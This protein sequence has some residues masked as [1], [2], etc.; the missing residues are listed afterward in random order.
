MDGKEWRGRVFKEMFQGRRETLGMG[1]VCVQGSDI[2]S[3][4]DVERGRGETTISRKWL[5]SLI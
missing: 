4:H 1:N 3:H 5:V 2:N